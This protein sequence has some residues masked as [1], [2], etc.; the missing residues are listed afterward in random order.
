MELYYGDFDD[1]GTAEPVISYYIDH[2]R[3]PIYSRDDL[4]QQIPSYNKRFLY[5]SDYAKADMEDIFGEK[6][7]TA[8]HYTSSQM[9]SILLENTGSKFIIHQLPMQAQWYPV[10]SINML[11]ANG[12]GKKDI[13]IGGNQT[14]SRIKFGAYAC[15]KGDV[16]INNGNC[17]FERLFPMQSGI[18][19][20]GD[21]RNAIVI[22][23][24]LIFGINDKQ[25]LCYS[26]YK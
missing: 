2:K 15:G 13:I 14:Y 26:F 16:F 3:W 17:R 25:P 20:T 9:S 5:F 6:L 24:Q 1:N 8:V 23:H 18:R 12:D 21:I 7:R 19:I 10:Y 22:G 11:D 4:I